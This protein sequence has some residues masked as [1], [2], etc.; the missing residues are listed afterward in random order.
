LGTSAQTG[1][2][3]RKLQTLRTRERSQVR[4]PPRA[5]SG[6][7]ASTGISPGNAEDTMKKNYFG[8]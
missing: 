4:N 3:H 8:G 5:S 7:R 6:I 2:D 1:F